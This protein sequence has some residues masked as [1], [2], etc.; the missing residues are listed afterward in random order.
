M[1]MLGLSSWISNHRMDIKYNKLWN[2][3]HILRCHPEL[4]SIISKN[5][6]S[7]RGKFITMF[8]TRGREGLESYNSLVLRDKW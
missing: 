3:K 6:S 1:V 4:S 5:K 7:W 2:I 8:L